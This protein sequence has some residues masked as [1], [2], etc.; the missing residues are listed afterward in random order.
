MRKRKEEEGI[1][2]S[3]NMFCLKEDWHPKRKE[4]IV[5]VAGGECETKEKADFTHCG[6]CD[7]RS[8]RHR[9]EA[10]RVRGRLKPR[11]KKKSWALLGREGGRTESRREEGG[12]EE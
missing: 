12:G 5:A 3:V 2:E 8:S 11:K 4:P 10:K 1:L 7:R 9:V 6:G